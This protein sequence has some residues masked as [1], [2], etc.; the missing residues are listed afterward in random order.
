MRLALFLF[1]ALFFFTAL[2]FSQPPD[3]LWTRTF[4]GAGNDEPIV[5]RQITNDGYI[6]AG[7]STSFGDGSWDAFFLKID[8][9]GNSEWQRTFGGSRAESAADV[10]R[11]SDGGYIA[12]ISIWEGNT[13][14]RT[15][16][17][18]LKLSENG[19]SLWARDYGFAYHN[20]A[21]GVVPTNAGFL[22][23]SDIDSAIDG[24]SGRCV[25]NFNSL[26]DTVQV[27]RSWGHSGSGWS[28]VRVWRDIEILESG[29]ISAS[30]VRHTAQ[31]NPHPPNT[32]RYWW[33]TY[34]FDSDGTQISAIDIERYDQASCSWITA[35]VL[36]APP[37]G[38]CLIQKVYC[39][40]WSV[41]CY[42]IARLDSMGN[43]TWSLP[44][45]EAFVDL[46]PS[47]SDNGYALLSTIQNSGNDIQI[48]IY[49]FAGQLRRQNTWG[50]T[51]NDNAVALC[52]TTDSGFVIIG[53]TTS[54]S[55][56]GT[57]IYIIKTDPRLGFS[58][59]PTYIA[60]SVSLALSS[61]PNPFNP[62]TTISFSLPREAQ[63]HIAV[64]DILGREVAVLAN[65]KFAIGE[66]HVTFDGAALPSGIYFARLQSGAFTETRKLL[67]LR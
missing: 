29:V 13:G 45:T 60:I 64:F 3:T 39:F 53:T 62:S 19:D 66:H 54:F 17:R 61:F 37:N 31:Q 22:A 44:H 57:D 11:T 23:I 41:A 8:S 48:S 58:A 16:F 21:R 33:Q 32:H 47:R 67:L 35:G 65:D 43:E 4:G 55:I 25:V 59:D 51:G 15:Y 36:A 20:K 27:E 2:A 24:L 7:R 38:D 46:A 26:G 49:D 52:G 42:G 10:R 18:L 6:V 9:A 28:D 14:A 63:T 56:G 12:A 5:I 40:D 30:A 1:I 34:C 50:G